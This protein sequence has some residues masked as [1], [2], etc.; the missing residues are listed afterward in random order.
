M[1]KK[2]V[3]ISSVSG[4]KKQSTAVIRAKKIMGRDDEFCSGYCILKGASY[5]TVRIITLA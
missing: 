4:L 2:S 1:Y 3:K 5:A